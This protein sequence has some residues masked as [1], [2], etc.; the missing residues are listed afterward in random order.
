MYHDRTS[1][2]Q[3]RDGVLW[4]IKMIKKVVRAFSSVG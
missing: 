1:Y 4:L 2:E 3:T